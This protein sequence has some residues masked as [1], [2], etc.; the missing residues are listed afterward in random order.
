MRYVFQLFISWVCHNV[1]SRTICHFSG[2]PST[3]RQT[4]EGRKNLDGI[5]DVFKILRFAL[6]DR[7]F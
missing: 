3:T 4:T 6:D 5:K 2:K 1:K 7:M